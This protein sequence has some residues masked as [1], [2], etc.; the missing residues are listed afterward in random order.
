MEVLLQGMKK[1]QHTVW[2]NGYVLQ[3]LLDERKSRMY[4]EKQK[5][6]LNVVGLCVC[7]CLHVVC[8]LKQKLKGKR[9]NGYA[10]NVDEIQEWPGYCGD[11]TKKII[12]GTD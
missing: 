4:Q 10:I 3:T 5:N 2:E 6:K 8:V 7:V 11:M 12:D 1:Y 9:I